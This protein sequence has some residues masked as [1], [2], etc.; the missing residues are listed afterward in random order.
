MGQSE[1]IT[2]KELHLANLS[3]QELIRSRIAENGTNQTQKPA[4]KP[5]L[6]QS[7]ELLANA[8]ESK[9]AF[10]DNKF[11]RPTLLKNLDTKPKV[12]EAKINVA[13]AHTTLTRATVHADFEK[14]A[15]A[16]RNVKL[17]FTRTPR[18]ISKLIG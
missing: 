16:H 5:T 3:I 10:I 9:G 12:V 2:I 4:T 6:M 14:Q 15:K 17:G 7:K 13:E 1:G 8:R 18:V 11:S